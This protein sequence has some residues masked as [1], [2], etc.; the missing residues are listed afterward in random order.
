MTL[1]FTGK[2]HDS[3]HM[4]Q[5]NVFSTEFDDQGIIP[6]RYTYL[7]ENVNPPL[8]IENVPNWAKSLI[9]LVE[10]LDTPNGFINWLVYDI[11]PE[12]EF[13]G[14][15]DQPGIPC[16]NSAKKFEY[17]GCMPLSED[18]QI[19]FTIIAVDATLDLPENINQRELFGLL[20]IH[21]IEKASITGIVHTEASHW[22]IE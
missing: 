4:D 21:Q 2:Y 14:E 6:D 16:R 10:D 8:I 19:R 20:S 11:D 7:G 17:V 12:T 1:E 15:G 5:I 9:L 22:A 3:K 13:I 18:H